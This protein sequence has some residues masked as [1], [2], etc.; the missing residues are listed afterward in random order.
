[1]SSPPRL[2]R[3]TFLDH[4]EFKDC[5]NP[6][7]EKPVPCVAY[8]LLVVEDPEYLQLGWL[9]QGVDEPEYQGLVLIRSCVLKV[10]EFEPKED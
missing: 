8:G 1:M 10:E 3:V 6:S 2:V 7:H 4:M 5:K 9:T